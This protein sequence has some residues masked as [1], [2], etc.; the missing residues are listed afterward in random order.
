MLRRVKSCPPRSAPVLRCAGPSRFR[1]ASSALRSSL[2]AHRQE[3]ARAVRDAHAQ[4]GARYRGRGCRNNGGAAVIRH[5]VFALFALAGIATIWAVAAPAYGAQ[6]KSEK[7]DVQQARQES[8]SMYREKGA[9]RSQHPLRCTP[10]REPV[11][12]SLQRLTASRPPMNPNARYWTLHWLRV[13]L[14]PLPVLTLFRAGRRTLS[15][16]RR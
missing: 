6:Q 1:R 15:L 7:S 14:W 2:A 16:L 13:A 8:G 4:A 5:T 9:R 3:V 10:L 11:Q 12:L